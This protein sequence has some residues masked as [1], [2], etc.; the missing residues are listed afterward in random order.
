MPRVQDIKNMWG[1]KGGFDPQRSD[2]WQ[3]DLN[4]VVN[5]LNLND[6]LDFLEMLPLLPKYFP[7]AMTLPELKMRPEVYRRDSR[8]YNM[9]GFDEPCDPVRLSFV[10]DAYSASFTGSVIYRILDVWRKLCRA[11]RGAFG[12][13]SS[14]TLNA[15]YTIEFRYPI[16]LYFCRGASLPPAYATGRYTSV[17]LPN[18]RTYQVTF[19]SPMSMQELQTQTQVLANRGELFANQTKSGLDAT[20]ILM[21]ENAWLGGFKIA[22]LSYDS[23]RVLTVDATIYAE[24]LFQ[25]SHGNQ[26]YA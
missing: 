26:V 9:P 6:S 5:G 13:E 15:Q 7:C 24:N 20:T 16:Y 3:A 1:I 2:L 10:V 11:G 18:R 19:D 23:A 8:P 4:A 22:D 14:I 25:I 12:S 21:L 17:T